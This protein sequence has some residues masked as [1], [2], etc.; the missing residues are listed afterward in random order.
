MYLRA[1]PAVLAARVAGSDRPPLVDGGP[2][3]E[4]R[5][6]LVARDPLY[7]EVAVHVVDTDGL[8]VDEV[9]AR[10]VALLPEAP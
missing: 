3:A 7:R 9:A 6:L 10:L 4:A 2:E 1:E 8:S 5:A